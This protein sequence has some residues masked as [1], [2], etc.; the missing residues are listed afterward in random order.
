MAKASRPN[1]HAG[2]IRTHEEA[3]DTRGLWGSCQASGS[4]GSCPVKRR[5]M[6]SND[7]DMPRRDYFIQAQRD[8]KESGSQNRKETLPEPNHSHIPHW[9]EPNQNL[10]QYSRDLSTRFLVCHKQYSCILMHLIL[11]HSHNTSRQMGTSVSLFCRWKHWGPEQ[12]SDYLKLDSF[13]MAAAGL[14]LFFSRHWLLLTSLISYQL[15]P[16]SS[17]GSLTKQPHTTS[18]LPWL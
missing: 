5:K 15:L 17:A 9:W 12:L 2:P 10:V 6:Y 8:R 13:N 7:G 11:T 4:P 18:F 16:N 14:N 1:A 3:K